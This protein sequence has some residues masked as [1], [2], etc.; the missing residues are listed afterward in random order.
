MLHR[1]LDK[2]AFYTL[3]DGARPARSRARGSSTTRR[4]IERARA[5]GR[6]IP[7]SSSRT[8][9]PRPG[10]R[11]STRASS[12][13]TRTT[14]LIALYDRLFAVHQDL[15]VQEYIPGERRRPLLG[16]HLPRARRRARGGV[17]GPQAPPVPAR[18]RHRDARREPLAARGRR[19]E[20]LHALRALGHRGY[21]VVEFKRDSRDGSLRITEVTGGRTWFPHGLVT[22]AGINLPHIWYCDVL[23]LPVPRAA[24]WRQFEEGLRWIHEERDLKTVW[25]YFLGRDGF[26]V[27]DWLRSYRGRRT[28]AYAAWDDPGPDP[29]VDPARAAQPGMRARSRRDCSR[30]GSTQQGQASDELRSTSPRRHAMADA[31]DRPPP[32]GARHRRPPRRRGGA[33]AGRVGG[34]PRGGRRADP[35]P[36]LQAADLAH[37]IALVEAGVLP[38]GRRRAGCSRCCSTCGDVPL[39]DRPADPALGDGFANREA[40]LAGARRRGRGLA[41]R[42]ARAARGNDGRVPHRRARAAPARSATRSRSRPSRAGRRSPRRHV[43][44]L[45]LDYTYLQQAQPTTLA[46]YLLGFAYPLLRDLDRLAGVLRADEPRARPASAR[47]RHALAARPPRVADAA[48]LRRRRDARARRHVAGRS[49]GRGDGAATAVAPEPRPPRRGPAGLVDAPSSASSSSPTATRA[50]AWSCRRRRTPTRS[51]SSAARRAR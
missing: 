4:E 16:R 29:H 37:A 26:G 22:R 20:T 17:D 36:G 38:R 23:G 43:D 6:A 51:P 21:G 48:R 34:P 32:G 33:R 9:R 30:H 1:I 46:H 15:L 2:K 19:A 45:T 47:Q 35:R 40:W 3:R 7:R 28:Y 8:S 25:L 10:G 41:L 13:P 27:R 24:G 50:A 18:L 44:T 11:P 5:V 49:A 31:T 39:A 12:S 42:R 14:M